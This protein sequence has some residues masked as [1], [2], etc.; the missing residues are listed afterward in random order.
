MKR[1]LC[2]AILGLLIVISLL[3]TPYGQSENYDREKAILKER[4]TR[5]KI[6]TGFEGD[7]TFNQQYVKCSYIRGNFK[8]VEVTAPQDTTLMKQ[9]FGQIVSRLVNHISA[10]EEDLL[11]G[12][13][14]STDLRTSVRLTQMVNGYGIEPGGWLNISYMKDLKLF[15]VINNTLDISSSIVVP[16]VS[17]DRAKQIYQELA[18]QDD[19]NHSQT[20]PPSIRLKYFNI[21]YYNKGAEPDY[22]LCWIIGGVKM[23]VIDA[24][25]EAIYVNKYPSIVY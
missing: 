7:V 9:V 24:V 15:S 25:S 18:L 11:M 5:F 21:N 16:T 1:Y 4:T 17:I 10:R 2:S 19:K 8:G 12:K 13:I 3:G 20:I 23:I 6:D 14:V 22:R